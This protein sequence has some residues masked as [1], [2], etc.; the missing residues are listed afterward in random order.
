VIK[1]KIIKALSVKQPW[2]WFICYGK[3]TIETRTWATNYRGP[4]LIVSSKQIDKNYYHPEKITGIDLVGL[5]F[6]KALAIVELV[7]CRF[8]REEDSRAAMSPYHPDLYSWVFSKIHKIEPFSVKGKLGL[9][10]I[11]MRGDSY[12]K[13]A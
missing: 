4:L 3:K 6:G 10:E 11:H 8:M 9:Y 2:A 5:Q 1:R 13:L 7:D 12:E